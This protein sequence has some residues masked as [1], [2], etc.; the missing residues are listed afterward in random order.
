MN[1]KEKDVNDPTG[2]EMLSGMG[3]LFEGV[4]NLLGRLSDLAEKGKELKRTQQFQSPTGK[5]GTASYGFSVKFA[6][7]AQQDSDSGVQPLVK[8]V[9][10]KGKAKEAKTKTEDREPQVDLF[11][12]TDHI[13]IV[14]ELPG[15][16]LD[17]LSLDF[18]DKELNLVGCSPRVRFSK[19]IELPRTFGPD[20][21]TLEMNNGVVEIRLRKQA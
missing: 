5:D 14:A 7:D 17:S 20:D 16:T 4:S 3:G 6:S 12:E 2:Q 15:V 13:S 10:S 11:E 1:E 19:S 21:V 9:N 8:T 18:K